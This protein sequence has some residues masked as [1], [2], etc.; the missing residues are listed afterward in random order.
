MGFEHG[1]G[2]KLIAHVNRNQEMILEEGISPFQTMEE[3]TGPK[4]DNITAKFFTN[5]EL[6]LDPSELNLEKK[7]ACFGRLLI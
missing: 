7:S 5:C 4:D 3:Y 1:P 2:K 6:I